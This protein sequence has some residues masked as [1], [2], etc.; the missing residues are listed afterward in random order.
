MQ[1]T[2]HMY[3]Y[4]ANLCILNCQSR[5][6][7]AIQVRINQLHKTC[8]QPPPPLPLTHPP[9]RNVPDKRIPYLTPA[10][11]SN[12]CLFT[13]T[14]LV[15]LSSGMELFWLKSDRFRGSIVI[16]LT[17][18]SRE[19]HVFSDKPNLKCPTLLQRTEPTTAGEGS[20]N[21]GLLSQ[22]R[23]SCKS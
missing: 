15:Y 4:I 1:Y 6:Q 12:L 10:R 7:A 16:S 21:Q 5:D 3:M 14:T 13:K 9:A 23:Q 17:Q 22:R 20:R 11:S 8:T 19:A 18:L 2:L